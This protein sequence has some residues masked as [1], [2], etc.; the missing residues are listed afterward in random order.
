MV[1]LVEADI[2]T[3][4]VLGW[5]GVHVLHFSG[6][7]CSQKLRIFLNL[8]GI[9]WQSH[10]I[11]LLGQ[12][13]LAALVS[14]H[15]S[16]RAG[17]GPGHDGAVHIE[18]NDIIQYLER[19]FPDAEAGS[20]RPRERGRGAAQARGR[21]ASRSA[22]A[23]LSLRVRA[24]RSAEARGRAGKLPGQR[25]GTVRRPQGPREG[26]SDR[27]LAARRELKAL[28]TTGRALRR[29]NFAPSSTRSTGRS[30]QQ[31]YLM[32]NDLTV[33]DIAW[34]IY[35][36]PA[37]ARRLSVCAAASARPCLGREAPRPAGICQGDRPASSFAAN[38]STPSAAPSRQDAGSGRR[39]LAIQSCRPSAWHACSTMRSRRSL[40]LFVVV[41]PIAMA[42]TFLVVT[43]GMPRAWRAERRRCAPASLP[44]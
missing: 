8:K 9:P 33:L 3:R 21:S 42:P 1:Q 28:P 18:S 43:E 15:Q 37:V 26:D 24:A 44:A 14:R 13:E 30:A 39:V 22:H 16:A 11:D 27:I 32:G 4:E 20:R 12:R 2:R 34:F 7:S 25:R 19:T 10:P 6:S 23:E 17:A 41:D 31:P 5:K 40:T 35:A 29:R 38:S 36:A